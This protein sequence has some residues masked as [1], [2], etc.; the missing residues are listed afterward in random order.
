MRVAIIDKYISEKEVFDL[1]GKKFFSIAITDKGDVKYE[2]SGKN[3]YLS[4]G[5]VCAALL[6]EFVTGSDYI[7]ISVAPNRS[8]N[9]AIQNICYALNWCLDNR[10]NY[11]CISAGTT[12]WLGSQPMLSLTK[13]LSENGTTIIA[14][15]SP[16]STLTFPA[17]YPWVIGVQYQRECR[18]INWVSSTSVGYDAVVGDFQSDVL[19]ALSKQDDFFRT[20]SSSMAVPYFL[21][22]FMRHES[23]PFYPKAHLSPKDSELHKISYKIPIV[24]VQ[25]EK[26]TTLLTLMYEFQRQKYMTALVT[27]DVITDWSKL[28]VNV[29]DYSSFNNALIALRNAS[30][31]LVDSRCSFLSKT[32]LFDYS[33]SVEDDSII[34]TYNSIISKFS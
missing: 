28:V 9:F 33:I 34:S 8:D 22:Y 14:A 7:A 10:I 19:D 18:F 11:I 26:T 32:L 15:V 21:S 20:R 6:A 2:F 27:A 13:Q 23:F 4:H 24:W 1:T 31:I 12:N 30:M 17:S 16:D 29:K 25:G 3:S 5:S